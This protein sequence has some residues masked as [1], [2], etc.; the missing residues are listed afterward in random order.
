MSSNNTINKPLSEADPKI[1]KHITSE[2][3]RQRNG[4]EMIPSE[5]YV[6]PA[7]LRAMGSIFTDKYSEGYPGKRYYGGQENT[8]KVESLAIERAKK[9]FGVDHVNV[10]PYSGSPANL[11]VY[12]A[13]LNP[14]DTIMGMDLR[15]GGHLT[16]GWK[17]NFS[18]KYYRSIPY[19]T[20]KNGYIDF[21]QVRELAKKERP[22]LIWAGAT[23]YPR[24]YDYKAFAEIAKEVGAFFAADIAHV[25]GL[26]IAGVH[27]SPVGH[28]DVITSTTHKTLRGPRAGIILCNGNQSEPLKADPEVKKENIPSLIDRAIFPGLQGGPHEHIIAGIAVALKEASTEEFKKGNEMIVKTNKLLAEILLENDFKLIT[29]GTDNHL[30][31]MDVT[32][33]NLTGKEAEE[34]LDKIGIS[35][36]KN[37]V[38]HDPRPPYSPSGI[39]LGTPCAVI[40]GMDEEAIKIIGKSIVETLNNSTSEEII[41]KNKKIIN[42]LCLNFPLYPDRVVE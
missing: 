16:H 33:K 35:V 34:A 12:F 28:A 18:S 23:A 38:P 30:I 8:D 15:H 31:L 7:V 19:G 26:I 5:S 22:K 39:R 24:K 11:A 40:R 2:L 6:S 20:T 37:A 25:I 41:S 10:Q 21:D 27:P 4:L 3:K 1:Y 42:E 32:N 9:L 17:V 29:G 14:G 36:N 13:L